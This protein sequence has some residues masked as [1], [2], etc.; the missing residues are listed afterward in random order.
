MQRHV[1]H[2]TPLQIKLLGT[3]LD[4]LTLTDVLQRVEDFITEKK[5]AYIVTP[6]VDHII[7]LRKDP[8]FREIY[9]HADLVLTDGAIIPWAACFLGAP[10]KES[11]SGV[12]LFPRLCEIASQR[13]WRLFFLGGR[14]GAADKAAQV[15]RNKYQ[16]LDIVGTYCPPLGFEKDNA[17][18]INIVR[19]IKAAKPDI[20]FVGL[21]APKQEKWIYRYRSQYQVPVS[22]GIGVSFEFI[23]GIVKRA[24]LWM[25]KAGLEW[26]WRLMMEPRR[27]WKRYLVDDMQFFWLVLKQKMG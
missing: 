1:F 27:L 24:P 2:N 21:G 20:I 8:E 12:D 6:N 7:R 17:E 19:M 18:N 10:L 14:E 22:I 25:R 5:T 23:S 13:G 9:E 15:L 4:N 3:K 11:I 26:F 16:G